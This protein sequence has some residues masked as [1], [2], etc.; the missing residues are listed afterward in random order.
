MAK[1]SIKQIHSPGADSGSTQEVTHL[2]LREGMGIEEEISSVYD[3]KSEFAASR[4]NKSYPVYIAVTSFSILLMAVTFGLTCGI[5]RDIEKITVGITDFRDLNLAELLAALKKAETELMNVDEKIALSKQAMDLEVEKIRRDA[6][7]E[8]KKV[9]QSGLGQAE[10][11]RL[12]DRI[13]GDY[14]RRM[15]TAQS[16][17]ESVMKEKQKE[18]EDARRK[19][20]MLEKKASLDKSGFERVMDLKVKS[21]KTEEEAKLEQQKKEYKTVLDNYE[22]E[23]KSTKEEQHNVEDLLGFYKIAMTYY[24]R[25]RGEHGCVIDPGTNGNMLVDINPYCAIKKGDRAYV[26]NQEGKVL[27]LVELN[28]EGIRLKARIVKRMMQ[29]EIQPFD[30]IL[31]I[32]N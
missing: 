16:N 8:I 17:Y 21:G 31:L 22:K 30:K 2:F 27:A 7:A 19:I 1:K 12:L 13:N 23:L 26:L 14:D 32:N 3:L 25:T 15:K 29:D 20:D 4:A 11:K 6:D 24:A 9:E 28:P 5:Q 18:A 10:K